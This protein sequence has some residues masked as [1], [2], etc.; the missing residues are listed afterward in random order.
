MLRKVKHKKKIK[1][2]S[3]FV[4]F[5]ILRRAKKKRKR[6]AFLVKIP[7]FYESNRTIHGITFYFERND[8]DARFNPIMNME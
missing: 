6:K 8:D 3:L 4:I 1:I 5:S 7:F 2:L